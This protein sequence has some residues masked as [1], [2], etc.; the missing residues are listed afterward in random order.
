[1]SDGSGGGF[2][3]NTLYGL[4]YTVIFLDTALFLAWVASIFYLYTECPLTLF[5]HA[6]FALYFFQTVTIIH[7]LSGW[8]ESYGKEPAPSYWLCASILSFFFTLTIFLAQFA[9]D[10]PELGCSYVLLYQILSGTGLCIS[11][12]SLAFW[13]VIRIMSR[14]VVRSY[15]K[16]KTIDISSV[17]MS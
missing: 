7:V 5:H 10:P 14:R 13:T 3:L 8:N 16:N 4:V 17:V 2:S 9:P 12:V 15:K 1:M 11:V 6:I